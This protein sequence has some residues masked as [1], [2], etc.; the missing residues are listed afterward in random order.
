MVAYSRSIWMDQ[1][2]PDSGNLR[3]PGK[4]VLWKKIPWKK[5]PHEK[6]SPKTRFSH[7][8]VWGGRVGSMDENLKNYSTSVDIPSIPLTKNA[9]SETFFI[10]DLFSR[11]FFPGD[12]FSA[13]QFKLVR[14]WDRKFKKFLEKY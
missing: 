7:S 9:F 6:R 10:R 2:N 1:Q 13:Y 14:N 3:N 8:F 5:G 11:D 12:L 4:N